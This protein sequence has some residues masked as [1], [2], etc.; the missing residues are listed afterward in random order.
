MQT[1]G[2]PTNS[3]K[4]YGGWES[5]DSLV[6][7]HFVAMYMS[8]SVMAYLSTG[9]ELQKKRVLYMIDVLEVRHISI[10]MGQRLSNVGW[11]FS[12]QEVQKTIG[13]GYLAAFPSDIFDYLENLQFDK[14]W[15]PYYMIHKIMV[16]L[17]DSYRFLGCE[18]ALPMIYRMSSYFIQRIRNVINKYTVYRWDQ[19]TDVEYGGMNEFM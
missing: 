16:A 13:T 4:P 6:R 12:T 14:V 8:A 1:A 19:I 15:A 2:L 10:K 11:C 9:D 17:F 5:P 7:G 3:S 18:K